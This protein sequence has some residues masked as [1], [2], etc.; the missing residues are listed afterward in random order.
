VEATF[1]QAEVEKLR[2]RQRDV[3]GGAGGLAVSNGKISLSFDV[4]VSAQMGNGRYRG[5]LKFASRIRFPIP[6]GTVD[7]HVPHEI[8]YEKL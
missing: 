8:V 6:D 5:S 3:R 4:E 2:R 7:R 1:A